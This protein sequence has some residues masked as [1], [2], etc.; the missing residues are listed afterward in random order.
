[1]TSANGP[2]MPPSSAVAMDPALQEARYQAELAELALRYGRCEE[3]LAATEKALAIEKE[4]GS[5]AR[6]LRTRSQVFLRLGRRPEAIEA[7]ESATALVADTAAGSGDLMQMASLYAD[8]GDF[9]KAI[10]CYDK[11]L[12]TTPSEQRQMHLM[13]YFEI[14]RRANRLDA[15]V[16][17]A[18]ARLAKK[19]DDREALLLLAQVY[20]GPKRDPARAVSVYERLIAADPRNSSYPQTLGMLYQETREFE[21]A[22]ALYRTQLKSA[23]PSMASSLRRTLAGAL[24]QAGKHDE[25][26]KEIDGL[27]AEA[28]EPMQ[29]DDLRRQMLQVS[30]QANR[31]DEVEQRAESRL[32]KDP[33]HEESLRTLAQIYSEM[34]RDPVKAL[35]V[36]ER[37]HALAPKEVETLRRLASLAVEARQ[38]D[39]AVAAYEELSGLE[40]Q[41][42]GSNREAIAQVWVACEQ[43]P[44]AI[45]A[46]EALLAKEPASRARY[47]EQIVSIHE[48]MQKPRDALRWVDALAAK[49][50]GSADLLSA[51]ALYA[52]CGAPDKAGEAYQRA[53]KQASSG[54]ERANIALQYASFL[55]GQNKLDE[56]RQVCS[57]II[58]DPE[59]P[60]EARDQAKRRQISLLDRQGKLD[61]VE[62]K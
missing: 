28:K 3:A 8:A 61:Q 42:G 33:K 31:L 58:A 40:P 15:F 4:A 22:A 39:R 48:R 7:L 16:A 54:A 19:P 45:A 43:W 17:D 13:S 53:M 30:R 51:A 20:N 41:M 49:A 11:M 34:K 46:Y 35:G 12:A 44:K 57:A 14:L 6:I 1:M 10:A 23:D 24:S 37:L 27:L 52:R 36:Y 38:P 47:V 5:R 26:L 62:V 29:R 9:D 60:R 56:A 59:A 25:A 32:A 2:G 21:K 55:E 18:E 50:N